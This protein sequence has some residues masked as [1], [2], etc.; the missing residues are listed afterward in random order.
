MTKQIPW[1]EPAVLIRTNG[2]SV[3]EGGRII[4]GEGPLFQLLDLADALAPKDVE[5]HYIALPER[6]TPPFRYAGEQI[7]QLLGRMD[8]PG[9]LETLNARGGSAMRR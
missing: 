2:A 7:V 4:V 1:R 8:R 3:H 9:M 5:R 6:R